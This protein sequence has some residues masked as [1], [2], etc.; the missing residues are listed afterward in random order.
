MRTNDF[1]VDHTED[2]T[3]FNA[4]ALAHYDAVVFLSTTGDVLNAAQQ[5]AFEHYIKGGGGYAGIHAAADTE[6]EWK[7][8]GQPRRRLLPQPPARDARG[9]T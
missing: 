1:Q 2:A 5:T 7:W 3:I 8:Y 9:A 4:A 6:Y